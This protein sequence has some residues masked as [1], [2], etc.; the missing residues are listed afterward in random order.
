MTAFNPAAAPL[1]VFGGAFDPPHLGHVLLATVALSALPEANLGVFPTWTHPS[2]KSAHAEFAHRLQM[3]R[4]AMAPLDRTEVS[5]LERELAGPG[6]TLHLLQALRRRKP[7]PLLYLLMGADQYAAR[8]RWHRFDAVT[9]LAT[10]LV[11][12]REGADASVRTLP[13]T[14]P[15]LSSSAVRARIQVGHALVGWLPAAVTRYIE[16]QGLYRKSAPDDADHG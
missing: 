2:G 16:A 4:R 9:A 1:I 11:V 12:G 3:C 6:Y 15:G 5:D 13:I 7:T 10:P 14:L 8:H